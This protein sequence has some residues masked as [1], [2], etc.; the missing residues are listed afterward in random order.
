MQSLHTAR[1]MLPVHSN[2]RVGTQDLSSYPTFPACCV[3]VETERTRL[4]LQEYS[5]E[6]RRLIIGSRALP[7]NEHYLDLASSDLASHRGWKEPAASCQA[8][9]PA[10]PRRTWG[11][12]HRAASAADQ[13]APRAVVVTLTGR[14]GT[15]NGPE[16]RTGNAALRPWTAPSGRRPH[17]LPTG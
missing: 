11:G 6:Q 15:G 7:R 1:A 12:Y 5:K 16:G 2:T 14:A 9:R 10:G 3:T 17:S 4:S 8:A 13:L